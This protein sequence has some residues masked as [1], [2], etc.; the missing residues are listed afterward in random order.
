[1]RERVNIGS[2]AAH[3]SYLDLGLEEGEQIRVDLIWPK[4]DIWASQVG[5]QGPTV[6]KDNWLPSTPIFE[7]NACTIFSSNCVH[8][9]VMLRWL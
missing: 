8:I 9:I 7:I 4:N 5:S 2:T 6:R 1:M 3:A